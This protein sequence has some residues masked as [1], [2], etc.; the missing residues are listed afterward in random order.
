MSNKERGIKVKN[1]VEIVES[2]R[3][4]TGVTPGNY[5]PKTLQEDEADNNYTMVSITPP[6]GLTTNNKNRVFI[7][8][9]LGASL[10]ALAGGVYFIKKKVLK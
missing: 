3:K 5:D 7:I 4:I 6:T 2:S 8:S 10:I 1:H 9:M